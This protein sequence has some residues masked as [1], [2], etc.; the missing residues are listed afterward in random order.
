MESQT[1]TRKYELQKRMLQ[2][3][4]DRASGLTAAATTFEEFKANLAAEQAALTS[5][6]SA[7]HGAFKGHRRFVRLLS[8]AYE[9]AAQPDDSSDESQ[10][11]AGLRD[12]LSRTRGDLE[13]FRK[14]LLL[15]VFKY[16]P[17]WVVIVLCEIPLILQQTG[18]NA[19]GYYKAGLCV[20]GS[21]VLVLILRAV[22]RNQAGSL[23]ASIASAL[24]RARRL[25]DTA[26][27][28]SEAHHQQELERIHEE[29]ATTTQTVEQQLKQALAEAG[30]RR[31]GCR[32]E[33]D[34]K[35]SRA[36]EKNSRQRQARLDQ[37]QRQHA[38]NVELWKKTAETRR[39]AET[40]VS[41]KREAKLNADYQAQWQTLER[42]WK[43]TL[44]PIYEAIESS[45]VMARKLFPP[46]E[47]QMLKAWTP[48][49]EFS[50]AAQFAQM[51]VDVQRL[52]ETTL[53]DQRLA[54]ARAV[55]VH[56][57]RS[58]WATRGRARSCSS[59]AIRDTTRP[60]ARSTTSS[61]G[62]SRP[63]RPDG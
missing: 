16:L 41:E 6:E 51:K 33:S 17:A 9:K 28:R 47:P 44:E 38:G 39:K 42:E 1:G 2:A 12:L 54:L 45:N 3:E 11:L 46:W 56:A 57:C 29:F 35:A 13:R 30:E 15:R 40:E 60:S 32:M 55:P 21:L 26:Q 34:E 22:A 59:P 23:A 62:C 25:H 63:R 43:Q 14:F 19:A 24:G 61:C 5:L 10:L 7:A 37:L 8:G 20:A 49:A 27:E 50:A 52:A 31:V 18:L 36:L 48:P 4:R 53:K 58:A